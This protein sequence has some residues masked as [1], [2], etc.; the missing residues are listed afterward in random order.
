MPSLEMQ[1]SYDLTNDSID[2][3]ITKTSAGNYALGRID[4]ADKKFIVSYVGR[5]DSDLNTRLKQHVGKY[6]LFKYSYASSPK[7]AFENECKNF[8]DFGGTNKLGNDIHPDRPA[9]TNWECPYCNNFD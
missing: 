1:G 3:V 5:S 9:N 6:P 4:K 7:A 2:K 8:H